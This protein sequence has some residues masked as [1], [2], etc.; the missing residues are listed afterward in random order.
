MNGLLCL[1]ILV[2]GI[3]GEDT[4]DYRIITASVFDHDWVE[5]EDPWYGLFETDSVFE[6]RMV[7]LELIPGT[8]PLEEWERP[9]GLRVEIPDE[10]EEPLIIVSSSE[11]E[12]VVGAVP[13]AFHGYQLLNPDTSIILNAP[14]IQEARLFTT[15][16][17]LF[18]HNSEIRQHITDTC[19]GDEYSSI[20]IAI[21][22]AGDL[23]RDGK[24]D[25]IIDDVN[26]SYYYYN[27]KLFLSSEA[28][29]GSIVKMVASF[30]DVYY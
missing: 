22:W 14:G 3:P 25:L 7:E 28:E 20:F 29:A 21:V 1:M 6:L 8:P 4:G 10:T 11:M 2:A 23:D 12:F 9:A 24:I 30:C 17:G 5:Y 15:E 27:Y 19:P 16:D 26:D 18:L 13:A